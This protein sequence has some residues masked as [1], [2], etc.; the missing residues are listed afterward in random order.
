VSS[1]DDWSDEIFAK[2]RGRNI[3]GMLLAAT[4][5]ALAFETWLSGARRARASGMDGKEPTGAAS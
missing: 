2:R 1:P 5:V 3:A 4:L